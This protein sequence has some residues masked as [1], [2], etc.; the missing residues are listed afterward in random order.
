MQTDKIDIFSLGIVILEIYIWSGLYD[1]IFE[2]KT[3]AYKLNLAV[4]QVI[5][6]MI[7]LNVSK[8]TDIATLLVNY[9]TLLK[10][11]K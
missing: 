8:R 11:F 10:Q 1:K 6:S 7:R 5:K 4:V 2:K 9:K 3:Q